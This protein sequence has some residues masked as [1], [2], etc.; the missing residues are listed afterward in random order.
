MSETIIR[1]LKPLDQIVKE[2]G[3]TTDGSRIHFPDAR[4]YITKEMKQY[5]GEIHKFRFDDKVV[6]KGKVYDRYKMIG[7]TWTYEGEWF[8]P[9]FIEED[10]FKI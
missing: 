1:K 9:E 6:R 5:F 3:G 8:E 2:F 10:E 4:I 7:N